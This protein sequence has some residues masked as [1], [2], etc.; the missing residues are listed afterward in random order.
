MRRRPTTSPS[1]KSPPS[2]SPLQQQPPPPPSSSSPLSPSD[3]LATALKSSRRETL[4]GEP[5]DL[6]TMSIRKFAIMRKAEFFFYLNLL[7]AILET[8]P[9]PTTNSDSGGGASGRKTSTGG[10]RRR[11]RPRSRRSASAM[12]LRFVQIA[13]R[14]DVARVQLLLCNIS[15]QPLQF[16]LKSSSRTIT[17]SEF[18]VL[19]RLK[20]ALAMLNKFLS[21]SPL[22]FS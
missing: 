9:P 10:S 5:A 2:Q 3:A 13:G 19:T 15:D 14:P 8:L 6:S 20:F 16:K 4:R 12:A 7:A 11:R 22:N 1:S 18:A 21:S 17:V